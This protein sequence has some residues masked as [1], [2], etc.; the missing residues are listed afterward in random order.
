MGKHHL[1]T[2]WRAYAINSVIV[3][4][5]AGAA[6]SGASSMQDVAVEYSA[7]QVVAAPVTAPP[8][9]HALPATEVEV[10][11]AK[12]LGFL[13]A[14]IKD[15]VEVSRHEFHMVMVAEAMCSRTGTEAWIPAETG[16]RES[17]VRTLFPHLTEEQAGAF[18]NAT[19]F[20][21]YALE[22]ADK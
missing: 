7:A 11:N 1:R 10:V 16:V 6:W 8:T 3:A 22:G 21:C 15:G 19:E 14:L 18:V 17:A 20:Y 2:N 9:P 4:T 13:T 12:A 5:M